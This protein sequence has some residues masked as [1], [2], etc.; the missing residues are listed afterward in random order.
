MPEE[1]IFEF[2]S[3]I[4]RTEI[5]DYLRTVADR[6][7]ADGTVTLGSDDESVSLD[8]P[9]I[10]EFEVKAEREGPDGGPKELSIELE[11]EWPEDAETAE[12]GDGTLRI[13]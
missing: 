4:R 9:E 8:V 1:V 5:A 7:D 12:S 2:E 10:P 6:L 13:E 11:M 3:E